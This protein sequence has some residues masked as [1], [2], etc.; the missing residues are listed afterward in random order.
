MVTTEPATTY[1]LEIKCLPCLQSSF[2]QTFIDE[3]DLSVLLCATKEFCLQCFRCSL[4]CDE[5]LIGELRILLAGFV[6]LHLKALNEGKEAAQPSYSAFIRS[7]FECFCSTQWAGDALLI[8]NA[9]CM[10]PSPVVGL[11][12][13][14]I[15]SA[16]RG[17]DHIGN[18]NAQ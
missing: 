5:S 3:S 14:F 10:R 17:L 6:A 15:I 4:V 2:L 8:G 16:Q 13:I 18:V 9:C 12:F 1:R 11:E 7:M